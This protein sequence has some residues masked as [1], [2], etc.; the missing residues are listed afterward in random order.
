MGYLAAMTRT[1]IRGWVLI[2]AFV[3][4]PIA[5]MVEDPW[6]RYVS[7]GGAIALV[8]TIAIWDDVHWPAFVRRSWSFCM[9]CVARC[10]RSIARSI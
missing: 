1:H 10:A 2:L 6:W 4:S 8:L 9:S 5:W 7:V 3:T